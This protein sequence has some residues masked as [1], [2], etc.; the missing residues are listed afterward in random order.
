MPKR[1]KPKPV[2][3]SHKNLESL[4]LEQ[5]GF[6]TSTKNKGLVYA[7][8]IKEIKKLADWLL[9]VLEYMKATEK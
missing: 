2:F 3:Q 7:T 5:Y 4:T 8:N 6:L 1:K 9:G